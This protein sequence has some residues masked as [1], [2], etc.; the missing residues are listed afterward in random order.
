MKNSL[1]SYN[2]YDTAL[3]ANYNYLKRNPTRMFLDGAVTD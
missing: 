1:L 3:S 2:K